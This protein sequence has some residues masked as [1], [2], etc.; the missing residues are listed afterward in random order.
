VKAVLFVTFDISED[1][2][3][4]AVFSAVIEELRGA[5]ERRLPEHRPTVVAAIS[6]AA[7]RA[8]AAMAASGIATP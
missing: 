7:D 8:I 5:V 4:Q 1:D 2:S 6:D 3:N